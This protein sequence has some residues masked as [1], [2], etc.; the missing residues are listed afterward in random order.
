MHRKQWELWA[1]VPRHPNK[2]HMQVLLWPHPS[3]CHSVQPRATLPSWQQA[4]PRSPLMPACG[5]VLR[6]TCRLHGPLRWELWDTKL[7]TKAAPVDCTMAKTLFYFFPPFI[8][9]LAPS[10]AQ[11]LRSWLPLNLTVLLLLLPVSLLSHKS[12]VWTQHW[13]SAFNVWTWMPSSAAR[14]AAVV[15]DTV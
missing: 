1:L 11:E 13:M 2:S 9:V 12:Q 7:K 5:E 6:W 15:T 10:S 14:G 8:K 3:E 4:L